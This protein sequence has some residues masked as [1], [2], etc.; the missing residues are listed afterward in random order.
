[1]AVEERGNVFYFFA[2]VCYRSLGKEAV[3]IDT[4]H[5]IDAD[6]FSPSAEQP[7]PGGGVSRPS[8][9]RLELVRQWAPQ[10]E[11]QQA[12]AAMALYQKAARSRM[13]A[14]VPEEPEIADFEE[15]EARSQELK[16]QQKCQDIA[17]LILV[18]ELED[19]SDE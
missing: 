19:S 3:V 6:T 8:V 11:E 14:G 18:D 4:N 5:G 2:D 13:P 15:L 10:A 9:D 12:E 1:M 16:L 17:A 7:V